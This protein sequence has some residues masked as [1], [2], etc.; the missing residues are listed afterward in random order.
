MSEV[1]SRGEPVDRDWHDD[2]VTTY[3]AVY[4]RGLFEAAD[5]PW[6]HDGNLDQAMYAFPAG[7]PAGQIPCFDCDCTG[8]AGGPGVIDERCNTCKG[9]G[10]VWVGL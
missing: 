8:W 7:V 6:S 1:D 9:T 5:F 2:E 10:R 4:G 3:I